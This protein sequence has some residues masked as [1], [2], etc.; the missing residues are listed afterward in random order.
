MCLVQLPLSRNTLPAEQHA[1]LLSTSAETGTIAHNKRSTLSRGGW[2]CNV[3]TGCSRKRGALGGLALISINWLSTSELPPSLSARQRPL[4]ARADLS[5]HPPRLQLKRPHA[6]RVL[7]A[8]AACLALVE[9]AGADAPPYSG[10]WGLHTG[11]E[12]CLACD[13]MRALS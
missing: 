7:L 3:A 10:C 2:G 8:L 13:D 11:C 6:M 12:V 9:A 1:M 5:S 4:D